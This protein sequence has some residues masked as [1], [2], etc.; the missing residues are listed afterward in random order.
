MQTSASTEGCCTCSPH[1]VNPMGR[2]PCLVDGDLHLV[3][4]DWCR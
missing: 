2:V 3:R 1:Q 4:G